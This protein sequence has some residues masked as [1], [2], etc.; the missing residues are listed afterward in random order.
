MAQIK[1]R[2]PVPRELFGALWADPAHAGERLMMTAVTRLTDESREFADVMRAANPEAT[3]DEL[4]EDE[5][6]RVIAISQVD[7][8][9]AGTPFFIA[10]V[11]AYV[12]FLWEQVRMVLRIAALHDRELPPAE[13]AAR[14]LVLRGVHPTIEQARVEIADLDRRPDHRIDGGVKGLYNTV[15]RFLVLIGIL[16]EPTAHDEEIPQWRRYAL[17]AIV[18]TFGGLTWVLTWFF[19]V[20]LMLLIAYSCDGSTRRLGS[21]AIAYFGDG[22]GSGARPPRRRRRIMA[23]LLALT[24]AVPLFLIAWGVKHSD[25]LVGGR[26]TF[27]GLLGLAVVLAMSGWLRV[28]VPR[29]HRAEPRDAR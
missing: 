5:R 27:I 7:G 18:F 23:A 14:I 6:R 19:P 2:V 25:E 21:R 22:V 3:P 4:C 20:T 24:I 17:L 12:A 28:R 8:A 10:L 11:P 13:M 1:A 16:G 26:R 15:R 29:R 9:V